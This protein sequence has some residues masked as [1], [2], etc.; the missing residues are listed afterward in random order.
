MAKKTKLKEWISTVRSRGKKEGKVDVDKKD[1]AQQDVANRSQPQPVSQEATT[2]PSDAQI[3]EAVAQ[4]HAEVKQLKSQLAAV[5]GGKTPDQGMA[6]GESK[7]ASQAQDS[8]K[9]TSHLSTH[10]TSKSDS[11]TVALQ[12]QAQKLDHGSQKAETPVV[13]EGPKHYYLGEEP[14]ENVAA[15]ESTTISKPPSKKRT[16]KAAVK[17][18][19]RAEKPEDAL[20]RLCKTGSKTDIAHILVE[21][22]TVDAT[23]YIECIEICAY[24]GALSTEDK[25]NIIKLRLEYMD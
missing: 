14:T 13:S 25:N 17:N 6:Q 1:A 20:L 9:E 16:V 12:G 10:P 7:D 23:H 18:F 19:I 15:K 24:R 11:P 22:T 2:Q 21:I 4:L 3:Q 8:V 5:T